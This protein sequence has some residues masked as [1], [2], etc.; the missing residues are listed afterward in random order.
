MITP[1]KM[2]HQELG[3]SNATLYTVPPGRT[4]EIKQISFVN[5]SVSSRTI[6]IYL[7]DEGSSASDGNAFLYSFPVSAGQHIEYGTWQVLDSGGMII[8]K[9]SGANV[10]IRI[11]GMLST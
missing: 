11:S 10:T 1:K 9:A 2:V 8:G 6:D 3:L 7:V 4:A 5:Y